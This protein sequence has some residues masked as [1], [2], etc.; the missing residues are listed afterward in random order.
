MAASGIDVPFGAELRIE[1]ASNPSS[2]KGDNSMRIASIP[3]V[4]TAHLAPV[5]I[6]SSPERGWYVLLIAGALGAIAFV[7]AGCSAALSQ[8]EGSIAGKDF[9][10]MLL[11]SGFTQGSAS[12]P[13]PASPGLYQLDSFYYVCQELAVYN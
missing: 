10:N 8:S 6:D 11:T 9:F 2:G 7:T 12:P 5:S 4:E 1:R 3:P 13:L